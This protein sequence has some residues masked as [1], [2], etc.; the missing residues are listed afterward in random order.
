MY[1]WC[2][3]VHSIILVLDSCLATKQRSCP[4]FCHWT[5]KWKS[6]SY[7]VSRV[8]L[9]ILGLGRLRMLDCGW[10]GVETI[11]LGLGLLDWGWD[12]WTVVGTIGLR[13]GWLRLLDCG[14]N[15]WTGIETIW[16]GLGL[17]N[18][19]WD[20]WTGVGMAETVG[21]W[22]ELL[23]WGWDYLTGVGTIGLGL[24]PYM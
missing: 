15:Y 2:V 24:G 9:I 17:L 20:Y 3:Y 22:L 6:V 23:N 7:K 8:G 18:C 4:F 14:W 1:V 19:G 5:V 10:T 11:G 21:L 16:L 12:Y 13:L